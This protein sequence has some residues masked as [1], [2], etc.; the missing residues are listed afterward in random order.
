MPHVRNATADDAARIGEIARAAYSKYIA[1]IGREPAPMLADFEAEISAGR[2]VVIETAGTIDGYMIAWPQTEAYFIDNLAVHPVRQGQG[3]GRRLIDH[4]LHAAR[5]H[6]LSAVRLYTNVAMTENLST[7]AHMGFVE[8]HR[9][10]ESGFQRVYLSLSLL[11][12][13]Q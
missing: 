6:G 5:R 11:N 10:V 12:S 3:L 13:G 2:V 8:T 4:A 9:S 7:Y 1:R